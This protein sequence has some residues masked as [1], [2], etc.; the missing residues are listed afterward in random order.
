[1][2]SCTVVIPVYNAFSDALAC[3]QSVRDHTAL[4]I[5]LLVIDDGSTE[6]HFADIVPQAVRESPGVELLRNERNLGLVKTCNMAIRRTAPDDVVLLN[7]DTLVTPR[8][9]EKLRQA[10]YHRAEVAT[11]TPLSNRA[12]ICSVPDPFG[13]N[14]LPP[15][16]RLAEYAELIERA[17]VRSYPE[18]P[19]CVGFCVYLKR[20]ALQRIGLF[21]EDTF[22]E[23]YGEEND[24]SCRAQAVGL[25]NILDDAT[26]VYHKGGRSFQRRGRELA[27]EHTVLLEKKHPGYTRRVRQF[28]NDQP[29]R[30]VYQRIHDEMLRCANERADYRVLHVVHRPPLTEH[31]AGERW[32]GGT[33]YHVA[34]LVHS[35]PHAAAWSLYPAFDGW[36]LTAYLP[37]LER[38]YTFSFHDIDLTALLDSEVFEVVHLHHTWGFPY[39]ALAEALLH[40]GNYFVSLHDFHLVCPQIN[41]LTP[42]GRFCDGKECRSCGVD[43]GAVES[44]R[45]T[46]CRVL[47]HAQG[48]FHFCGAMRS[49]FEELLPGHF[50]WRSMLHGVDA[51]PSRDENG[52]AADPPRPSAQQPLKVA[53]L[54]SQTFAKGVEFIERMSKRRRLPSGVP[55]QW[56]SIGMQP[57]HLRLDSNVVQ[58]GAYQRAELPAILASAA[59]HLV[60]ILSVTPE[61]Y[62]YT[63][64]E[65]AMCGIPVLC[66][67]IG[68]PAERVRAH[69]WGWVLDR[70]DE[71]T[72]F[73]RLQEIVDSWEE[74]CGLRRRMRGTPPCTISKMGRQYGE[75]YGEAARRRAPPATADRSA[76][77]QRLV[78]RPPVR[79][80]LSRLPGADA[81]E[82]LAQPAGQADRWQRISDLVAAARSHQQ[83]NRVEAAEELCWQVLELDP[84]HPHALHLLGLIAQQLK[85]P[86]RA[87][88]Y[89]HRATILHPLNTEFL[90]NLGAA[91]RS[92]RRPDLAETCYRRALRLE[93]YREEIHFNLGNTLARLGRLDA[94]VA[95]YG[96]ALRINGGNVRAYLALGNVF[97]QQEKSDEAEECYRR[98]WRMQGGQPAWDLRIAALCPTVFG[99]AQEQSRWRD[100]FLRRVAAFEQNQTGMDVATLG[101]IGCGPPSALQFLP[102]N[103]RPLKEAYAAIFRQVFADPPQ[104][105]PREGRAHI[106]FLVTGGRETLFLKSMRGVLERLDPELAEL[107]IIGHRGAGSR[108]I[109]EALG[110]AVRMLFVPEELEKAA[111]VIG[112]E[113]FDVLYYWEVGSDAANYFLPFFR[114]AP[115]QCASWGTPATSG[116]PA[117]EFYLSSDLVEPKEAEEHY[118]EELLRAN[119]LPAWR[120]P[121][122]LPEGARRRS[123]FGFSSHDHVYVCPH[124]LAT[125]HP[126]FDRVLGSLL[127]RDRQGVL[128]LTEDEGGYAALRL[129]SRFHRT[130]P[131]VADRIVFFPRLVRGD[132]LALVAAADVLLD[133]IYCGDVNATY[134]ALSLGKPMVT[135]PTGSQRGR[136]TL[137]CYRKMNVDDCIAADAPAYVE[138][139]LALGT[140]AD[141]RRHVA[142]RIR[143]SSPALFRD[144]GAVREYERL[145]SRL[146]QLSRS[147]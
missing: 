32:P 78:A 127:A 107:V 121:A 24:L 85:D 56:H 21:D 118:S 86:M 81:A 91:C 4:E 87:I 76:A 120:L 28:V 98:A 73:D 57:A 11:V 90:N 71:E 50:P 77:L 41:R 45:R 12:T 62:C 25:V 113:D 38:V 116:I 58:H 92:A 18:L 34:D 139:A 22:A 19:T 142:D 134:D 35:V 2:Q 46:T 23:G 99:S 16:L 103:L 54:G 44:L 126:D 93:P 65:A 72:L 132:H 64:D 130:L 63:L 17:S 129:R 83:Q 109:Q 59:P 105:A 7:S 79:R 84:Q 133:P 117:M 74:Y 108:L 69:G 29:L 88:H 49:Y 30:P 26:L 40:H 51:A 80:P 13:D 47:E 20:E 6:G 31:A 115:L 138:R 114:L 15:S 67:P 125:I 89:I 14:D 96:A 10:A 94:A 131:A 102:G 124:R 1:M 143:E 128:A 147:R 75:L 135:M 104:R 39:T 66:T 82:A 95:S 27:A 141:L 68:A 43:D 8:W 136:H 123:E 110:H 97:T 3:L 101:V 55:V 53:L 42:D 145:L 52:G 144:D 140:D 112:R 100:R 137:G 5:R 37:G 36:Y 122:K 48:V 61:A 106:G 146:I 119:T 9:L 70:L 60:A 33:E 111:E